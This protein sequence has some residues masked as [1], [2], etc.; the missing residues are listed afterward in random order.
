MKLHLTFE[1][2]WHIGEGAGATGHIDRVVRRHPQDGLPYVPAKTLTGLLRDACEKIARGLDEDAETGAWQHFAA[3]L[4]GQQSKGVNDPATTSAARVRISEAR[5]ESS[6]RNALQSSEELKAALTFIKPGL[7]VDNTSGMA[8][9]NM[10]RM[11][12][13]VIAGSELEAE[14]EL[15]DA[16]QGQARQAAMILLA[17]GCKGVER[18]GAKRRRGGGRCKLVLQE[19]AG[20]WELLDAEPPELGQVDTH[21][22]LQ[23]GATVVVRSDAW[24]VIPL[25]LFLLSP[26]VIPAGTAGNV[27]ESRDHIPGSL[28][29]PALDKKLRALLGDRAAELTAHLAAGRIQIHNAYPVDEDIRL[30]PA[31]AA[32]MEEKDNPEIVINEL[33]GHKGDA[34]QRKQL[35]G[36]Y[37]PV[38]FKSQGETRKFQKMTVTKVAAT[39]AVIDDKEQRPNADVGGVYT[40]EAIAPGQRFRAELWIN[41]GVLE[42]LPQDVALSGIVRIGRAK[43]DDYGRV[44]LSAGKPVTRTVD[45]SASSAREFSLWIASPLLARDAHLR[46]ITDATAF[47]EWLNVQLGTTLACKAAF[48]RSF[49][50]DGWNNAWNEPRPTR[51]GLAAGSCFL[52]EGAVDINRLQTLVQQG[53]GERRGEGYGEVVLN[54]PLLSVHADQ[55]FNAEKKEKPESSDKNNDLKNADDSFIKLLQ[56]RALRTA[57]RRQALAQAAERA[58]EWGWNDN[59][60][61]NSQLGA[62]RSQFENWRGAAAFKQWLDHLEAIANRKEKWPEKSRKILRQQA[63]KEDSV[64]DYIKVHKD[65]KMQAEA[66]RIFWLTVIGAELDRRAEEE[67]RKASKAANKEGN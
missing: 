64:W 11:E 55:P 61:E 39:H 57:L 24:H 15:D 10:L 63:E 26:V 59:K 12:E 53:L 36:G 5:F 45:A 38:A 32:L 21:D 41:G 46:P 6:L 27:I 49:R 14:L 1:S 54:A 31:P 58:K 44:Q 60:P 22:R 47:A 8:K 51:F 19:V 7:E 66:T 50:D 40:Y 4:F 48:V 9:S 3:T 30:L 29:L 33:Y 34:V 28:L 42:K 62:L 67:K 18:I 37:V 25:D 43:K 65:S 35:R 52:F 13:V 2:D 17:A 56:R 20:N 16:L 23:L